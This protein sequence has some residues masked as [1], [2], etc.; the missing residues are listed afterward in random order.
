MKIGL[1]VPTFNAGS[2]WSH[3]L[4]ALE[5]QGLGAQDV[6]VVDSSSTD[7]TARLAR[8]R[9]LKVVVIPTGQFG[10]GKTRQMAVDVLAEADVIIFVTQDAVFA[11]PDAVSKLVGTFSD[12]S[13]GMAYGRQLPHPE[14]GAIAAHARLFNYPAEGRVTSLADVSRLGIRAAFASNSFAAYRRVALMEVGGFPANVILGEDTYV[15]AKLLLR[16]WKLAYCAEATVY[17]SHDYSVAEE[18]RRYFDTGVFH[19]REP[20]LRQTFGGAEGEGLR[21]LVSEWKYLLEKNPGLLPMSLIRTLVKYLGFRM[22]L[23]EKDVPV[24]FKRWLSM[25]RRY[26]DESA[27]AG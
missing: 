3:W 21:F 9:G 2:R 7:D 20:W 17:H 11:S 4:D 23:R 5:S 14:A 26:W 22:G 13:V 18:F 10:H 6:L 16:G 8:R 1:V 25:H 12:P 27:P 24:R 19:A 15:A